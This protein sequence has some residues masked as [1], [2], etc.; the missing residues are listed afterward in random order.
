VLSAAELIVCEVRPQELRARAYDAIGLRQ[1]NAKAVLVFISP[2]GQTGP[3]ANDPA[4]DLTLFFASSMA[5]LL[6]GQ[7]DDLAEP[8]MRPVGEQSAFIGG[9]TAAC[10]GMHAALSAEHNAVIDVSIQEAL[11][12]MAVTEL[13]RAG[14]GGKIWSRLR[15]TDGNGATV[16]IL[17]ACDGYAAIS[18][19]EDR[20]WAAWLEVMGSP[21]WGTDSRFAK[22]SDRVANWE[23]LHG[24]M[25]V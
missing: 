1:I 13:A 6:T 24:V 22:K 3:Q 10:A 19:R 14:L 11:A 16:T 25:S 2:F 9:L 12:T 18:P 15:L 17:P 8:P 23:A 5:R 4:T 21:N 7:V 20:Q